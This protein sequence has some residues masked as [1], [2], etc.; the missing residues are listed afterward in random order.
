M[1]PPHTHRAPG[2]DSLEALIAGMLRDRRLAAMARAE[3][4]GVLHVLS[5]VRGTRGVAPR[6]AAWKPRWAAR[7]SIVVAPARE[8]AT[9]GSARHTAKRCDGAFCARNAPDASP[10]ARPEVACA[11]HAP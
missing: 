6:C 4:R 2:A 11:L 3:V 7:A 9:V 10:R 8:R 1:Y 5:A